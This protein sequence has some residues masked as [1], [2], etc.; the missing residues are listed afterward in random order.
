MKPDTHRREIEMVS[1]RYKTVDKKV[2][3]AAVLLPA[4]SDRKKK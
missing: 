1:M 2:K 4:N 3:P